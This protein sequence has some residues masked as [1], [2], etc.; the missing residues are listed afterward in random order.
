VI[1]VGAVHEFGSD[2]GTIPERSWLRSAMREHAD[3]HSRA[4]RKLARAVDL[5]EGDPNVA[6]EKLGLIAV[7]NIQETIVALSSP[8]NE[9]ATIAAKGSSN[10]L[11]DTGHL[12][13]AVTHQVVGKD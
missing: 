13:Q 8:P 4:A 5:G 6:L 7:G 2:D 11:V 1:L 3:E 9:A 10:P 12:R